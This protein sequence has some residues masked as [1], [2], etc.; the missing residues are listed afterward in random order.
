MRFRGNPQ[1]SHS[2]ASSRPAPMV[3][4]IDSRNDGFFAIFNL[5]KHLMGAME[6]FIV[7]FGHQARNPYKKSSSRSAP[8][9]KTPRS[10]LAIIMAPIESSPS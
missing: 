2:M 3:H 6:P 1:V 5:Y 9:L 7:F 8:S 10:L 4:A